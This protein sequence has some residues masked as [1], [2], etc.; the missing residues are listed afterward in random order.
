MNICKGH[1][2][3]LRNALI[4]IK[5]ELRNEPEN[6]RERVYYDTENG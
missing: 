1:S 3:D 2:A 4:S 6:E 5:I